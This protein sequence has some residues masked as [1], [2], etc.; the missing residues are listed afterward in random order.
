M[1]DLH[2]AR[3]HQAVH[4]RAQAA[5]IGRKL[6][7]KHGH[8]AIGKIDAG[9]AQAGFL[10]ERRIRS[11]VVGHVGDVHLQLE[12]SILQMLHDHG[13]IEIARGLSID[14]DNG[15]G[16]EVAPFVQLPTRE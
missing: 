15:Q 12:V 10:I 8:G 13:V 7:R 16:A 5:D 9:A 6:E 3:H 2:D 1:I 4:L 11:N 14:S